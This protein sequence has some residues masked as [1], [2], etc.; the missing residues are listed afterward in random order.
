MYSLRLFLYMCAEVF[1]RRDFFY[2]SGKG[3]S[4]LRD[5]EQRKSERQKLYAQKQN[6][7]QQYTT[8][9]KRGSADLYK[10]QELSFGK[11]YKTI[12]LL[13]GGKTSML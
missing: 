4:L 6:R 13:V 2:L 9:M 12:P 3:N 7:K 8:S 5:A 11:A 1:V 10:Q